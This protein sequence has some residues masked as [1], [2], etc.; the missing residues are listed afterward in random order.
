M[1]RLYLSDAGKQAV[2]CIIYVLCA[3]FLF[4]LQSTRGFFA[5]LTVLGGRVDF[6]TVFLVCV[7]LFEGPYLSGLLGF[8]CGLLLSITTPWAEGLDALALSLVCVFT[9]WISGT[10]MRRVLP[11][12]LLL[13]GA[14]IVLR[15]ASSSFFYGY[16]AQGAR[17]WPEL[18]SIVFTLI[19]SLPFTVP[20]FFLVQRLHHVF[21]EADHE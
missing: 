9:A 1:N 21:S 20:L 14:A 10:Y 13:G 8:F 2:R 12:A 15:M 3:V 17:I 11:T 19:L 4:L 6:L 18:L 5:N 16:L 7:A